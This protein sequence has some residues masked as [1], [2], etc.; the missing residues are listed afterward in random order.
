[1]LCM[2]LFIAV[3]RLPADLTAGMPACDPLP[4]Q[5]R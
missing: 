3:P 2:L 4:W 1:M 5:P